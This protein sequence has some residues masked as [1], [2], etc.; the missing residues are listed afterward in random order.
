MTTGMFEFSNFCDVEES[1]SLILLA[2]VS[3][4]VER[5]KPSLNV[6][7][8]LREFRAVIDGSKVDFFVL[9]M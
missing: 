2:R 3:A 4:C 7:A 8:D 6:K 1:K 9:S 5:E